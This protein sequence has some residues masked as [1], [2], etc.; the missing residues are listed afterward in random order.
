LGEYP[1]IVEIGNLSELSPF[2]GCSLRDDKD[3]AHFFHGYKIGAASSEGFI[4]A[5]DGGELKA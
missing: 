5:S 3:L 1:F 2:V 4:E